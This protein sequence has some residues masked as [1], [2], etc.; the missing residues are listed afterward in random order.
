M[1]SSL[2]A[3]VYLG[4]VPYDF[5]IFL[6]MVGDIAAFAVSG[7]KVHGGTGTAHGKTGNGLFKVHMPQMGFRDKADSVILGSQFYGCMDIAGLKLN[8]RMEI[9]AFKQHIDR[10]S[11]SLLRFLQDKGFVFKQ[12]QVHP[13]IFAAGLFHPCLGE[14]MVCGKDE[15]HLLMADNVV[16]NIAAYHRKVKKG[17]INAAF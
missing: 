8:L 13:W 10:F 17:Q 14:G 15:Q 11:G 4:K 9:A 16:G 3:P 2:F 5:H 7:D 12:F 1:L 6:G